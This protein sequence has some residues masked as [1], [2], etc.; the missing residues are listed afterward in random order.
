M[1][2]QTKI[3]PTSRNGFK[4]A[5]RN[6]FN[7]Y[8]VLQTE[9][10]AEFEEMFDALDADYRPVDAMERMYFELIVSAKWR[11]RRLQKFEAA[12]Y[13]SYVEHL[14]KRGPDFV[15]VKEDARLFVDPNGEFSKHIDRVERYFKRNCNDFLQLRAQTRRNLATQSQGQ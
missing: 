11:L 4:T 3:D 7:Q 15:Y 13:A 1:Y 9:N 14:K 12:L 5:A 8:L 2:T 10:V 6:L